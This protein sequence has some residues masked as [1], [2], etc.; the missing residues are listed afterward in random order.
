MRFEHRFDKPE[1]I[2]Q[3]RGDPG[4][5]VTAHRQAAAPLRAVEGERADDHRATRRQ[6]VA[7]M[8]DVT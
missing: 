3:L 6:D 1:S 2:A 5:I 7:D 8:R 4:G